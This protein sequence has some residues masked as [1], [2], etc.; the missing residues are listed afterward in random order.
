MPALRAIRRALTLAAPVAAAVALA[1]AATAAPAQ[2]VGTAV[3]IGCLN[4]GSLASFTT[5]TAQPGPETDPAIAPGHVVF[6]TGP[7]IGIMPAAGQVSVA[8]LNRDTGAAGMAD[9]AG[10]Y[11]NLSADVETGAGEVLV[12]VFGSVSLGS[13]PLCNS[14]PATGTVVV[15]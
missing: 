3:T 14:T 8:W 10:T 4:Q 12:T 9:L 13:G 11:P 1:G 6:S 2:P 7:A 5:V 15:G